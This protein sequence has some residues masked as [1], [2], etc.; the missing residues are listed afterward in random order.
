MSERSWYRASCI[1]MRAIRALPAVDADDGGSADGVIS[2]RIPADMVGK[3]LAR[4]NRR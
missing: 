1:D 2:A 3:L 4:G